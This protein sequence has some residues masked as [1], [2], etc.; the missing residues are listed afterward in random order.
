MQLQMVAEEPV[1]FHLSLNVPDLQKAV[2][3][4]SVLFG[5]APAKRHDDYAKFDLADPPLVFSLVPQ[6]PGPGASLSHL[7]FRVDSDEA[8]LKFRE[9]LDASKLN[10]ESQNGTTC[11]YARQNKLWTSD[12]FGN[13]WEIYR[14][15]EDV[16]PEQI[17]T[18]LEGRAA[19]LDVPAQGAQAGAGIKTAKVDDPGCA[20][21][22][23]KP[24]SVWEHFVTNPLPERIPHADG[25][26]DE[27]RLTGTFNASLTD[28]ERRFVVAESFRVLKPGGKVTTHGLMADK[29]IPG[30]DPKLPGLAAMVS[31]VPVQTEPLEALEAAGFT[32]MQFVKFGEKPW[33]MHGESGL[34][35]VK[36]IAWKPAAT[37][38][39]GPRQVIYK[40]PFPHAKADG[41]ITFERGRRTEVS[42]LLWDQLRM[43]PVAEQFLFLESQA[44]S[45]CS[46]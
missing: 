27:V 6:T 42:A 17:R 14:I 19:R 33:F 31:R 15:E 24:E 41:G 40:G 5:Q 36:L 34:R 30:P 22:G 4:Y 10:C 7:G 46:A 8:I 38:I 28:K 43:G 2:E 45:T 18:S 25:S 37:A 9:R 39:A 20:S 13:V 29:K 44:A 11:A 3:F 26:V 23:P 1:R 35:E 32:G 12:P 16:L 21:G